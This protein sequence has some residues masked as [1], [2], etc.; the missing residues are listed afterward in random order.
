MPWRNARPNG[1][2]IDEP[3]DG[4]RD[5]GP[6]REII[7]GGGP[8][9][10]PPH[11]PPLHQHGH[12]RGNDELQRDGG[13]LDAHRVRVRRAI[14]DH[15]DQPRQ[16]RRS[17]RY[18]SKRQCHEGEHGG[19]PRHGI[20]QRK[21]QQ[22]KNGKA[23]DA[24]DHQAELA[25]GAEEVA[26]LQRGEQRHHQRYEPYSE[27]GE[28]RGHASPTPRAA[29]ARRPRKCRLASPAGPSKTPTRRNCVA[30]STRSLSSSTTGRI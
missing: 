23:H 9:P 21:H 8:Q 19:A 6:A 7:L 2:R 25:V 15:L 28:G 10:A 12:E 14:S 4:G 27:K 29:A 17:K 26:E 20:S 1:L 22:G 24:Q 5:P 13:V 30:Y 11:Q 16:R 18:G 3:G